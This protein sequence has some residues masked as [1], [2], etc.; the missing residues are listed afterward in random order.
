MRLTTNS[1]VCAPKRGDKVR[2]VVG[3]GTHLIPEFPLYGV[4]VDGE[5]VAARA[6]ALAVVDDI[7]AVT[8]NWKRDLNPSDTTRNDYRPQ[9][10]ECLSLSGVKRGA[11][12]YMSRKPNEVEIISLEG[13]V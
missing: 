4:R 9:L 12:V 1:T 7:L 5:L 8:F 11:L 10:L 2:S 3:Y 13:R 6:D